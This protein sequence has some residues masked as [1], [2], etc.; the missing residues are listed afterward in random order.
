MSLDR[1]DPNGNYEP[2]NCRWADATTQSRNTRASTSELAGVYFEAASGKW[3]AG[4]TVNHRSIRVGA[5]DSKE[6]AID[7]RAQ[8][9][10]AYWEA[11]QEPLP[12]GSQKNNQSGYIGLYMDKRRGKWTAY[13]GGRKRR[14][15]IGTFASAQEALAARN[16]WLRAHGISAPASA[17]K[18]QA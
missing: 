1:I 18:E 14:V 3:V 12:R 16:D 15:H 6:A 2:S 7:A 4:I 11:G 13:Y 10:A 8:A 9:R 17:P 5:F